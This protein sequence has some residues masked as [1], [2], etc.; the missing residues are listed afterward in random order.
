MSSP[1]NQ[2]LQPANLLL[3]AGVSLFEITTLGQPLE[4]LKTHMAAHRDHKLS[5]AVQEVWL[6]GSLKTN[7]SIGGIK[8]FYQGELFPWNCG[9]WL[10]SAS[11][12]A[13][14]LFTSA[15]LESFATKNLSLSPAS[16]GL[17]GGCGGGIAQAYLS[18]GVCTTM[19]TAEITRAK[20]GAESVSKG[21]MGLFVDILKKEGI[22]GVNKGV[23]AVALRQCTNWGS[24]MGFA[25]LAEDGIRMSKGR[26][27]TSDLTSSDK[28]FSS[29]I[30]GVLGCWN[31]PI[32]V[33]R[34][35]M[36][37]MAKQT[38]RRP[39]KKTIF[40]TGSLIFKEHGIE[41]LFKGMVPRMG[42]S[43]WRTVCFVYVADQVK[44]WWRQRI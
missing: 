40:S 42:L 23:H 18:M 16:A 29:V 24:R 25:R 10:E 11:S 43:V 33:I 28:F 2:K 30:G 38:D 36:Q 41:G 9:A 15:E 14:L 37:S 6:R 21:T 22:R 26:S 34:V 39:Q 44:L 19:K 1:Q 13:I 5:S 35:E 31:H 8:G 32:E 17:L 20:Q 3:G 4:V 12:G 27:K 7:I